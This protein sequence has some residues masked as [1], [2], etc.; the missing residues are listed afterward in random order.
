MHRQCLSAGRLRDKFNTARPPKAWLD[1][2]GCQRARLSAEKALV[3]YDGECPARRLELSRNACLLKLLT[4][5]PPDR[6]GVFRVLT[7]G[8]TLKRV[9]GDGFQIDLSEPGAHKTSAVF[10]PTCT[11]VTASVAERVAQLIDADH[12]V[13]GESLFHG[14]DRRTPL[15]PAAFTQLVK[16]A[17]K[18]HSGVALCPK[19]CRSS[20]ITWMK[21]GDHGD[22]VCRSAAKAMKHSST[23]ADSAAYDK[24]K[25]ARVVEAAMRA[26]DTFAKQFAIA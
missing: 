9:D 1:W 19:D 24:H 7:M 20:F 22:E 6:V 26:A 4:S 13:T 17:F 3:G 11:T 21:D 15:S 16:A 18:A 23:V 5:M 12:L 2:T 14:A 8:G 25:S 10:G